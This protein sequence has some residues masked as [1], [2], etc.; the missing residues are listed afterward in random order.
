[1]NC[2]FAKDKEAEGKTF[3]RALGLMK[4]KCVALTEPMK[5]HHCDN[6]F[7]FVPAC[8]LLPNMMVVV[9]VRLDTNEFEKG[10]IY[11]AP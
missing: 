5:Y 7:Y 11:N 6:I 10:D 3:K 9:D 8:I 1:L 4:Q 2:T